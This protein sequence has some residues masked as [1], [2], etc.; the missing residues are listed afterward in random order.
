MKK[1][2]YILSLLA[3]IISCD[4]LKELAKANFKF[5]I[6]NVIITLPSIGSTL[7]FA[8][9]DA[10][11]LNLDSLI[12]AQSAD[13]NSSNIKKFTLNSIDLTL[14]NPD[15]TNNFAN[16]STLN[17]NLLT[18]KTTSPQL[19]GTITNTDSYATTLNVPVNQTVDVKKILADDKPTN[20]YY[21]VNGTLRRAT[22]KA[23]QIKVKA[24]YTVEAGL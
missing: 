7:S 18:D 9:Q 8:T 10:F 12:K 14:L 23:L 1:S 20:F 22:T 5:D 16:F 3:L 2:I 24:N 11:K 6:D 13:L 15:S 17:F 21:V 19:I 4:K